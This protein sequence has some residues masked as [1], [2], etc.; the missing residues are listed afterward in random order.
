MR[1]GAPEPSTQSQSTNSL[2]NQTAESLDGV[3]RRTDRTAA[4]FS[5]IQSPAGQAPVASMLPTTPPELQTAERAA[6][7][8]ENLQDDQPLQATAN[9]SDSASNS[10]SPMPTSPRNWNGEYNL[11]IIRSRAPIKRVISW[12]LSRDFDSMSLAELRAEPP[13]LGADFALSGLM[14][15]LSVPGPEQFHKLVLPGREDTFE[16]VKAWFTKKVNNVVRRD[17]GEGV[18]RFDIEI[19]GMESWSVARNMGEEELF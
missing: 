12:T 14:F 16:E 15:T 3:L 1:E 6:G 2:A 11:L 19:E 18:L 5:P 4:I 7:T 10:K 17:K 8:S 13:L 9:V